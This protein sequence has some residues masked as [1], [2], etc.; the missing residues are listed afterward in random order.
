MLFPTARPGQSSGQPLLARR[1]TQAIQT[2]LRNYT[3]T[4]SD[5]SL[6]TKSATGMVTQPNNIAA[7]MPTTPQFCSLVP[8]GTAKCIPSVA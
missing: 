6:S 5:A 1:T 4:V 7:S 8:D 2:S 3:G